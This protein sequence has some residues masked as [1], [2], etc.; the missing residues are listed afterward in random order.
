M[1]MLKNTNIACE[2]SIS[3]VLGILSPADE[4]PKGRSILL[5]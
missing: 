3:T 4:C 5:G 2:S 1:L